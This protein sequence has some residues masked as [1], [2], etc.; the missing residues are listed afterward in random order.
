M[1]SDTLL[2]PTFTLWRKAMKNA[3]TASA[4]ASFRYARVVRSSCLNATYNIVFFLCF[5]RCFAAHDAVI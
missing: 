4:Y 2:S 3:A 1:R 5:C